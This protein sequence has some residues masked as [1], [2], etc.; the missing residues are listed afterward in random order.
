MTYGQAVLWLAVRLADGLAHAH[1]RGILHR[2][3]KPAN[4]L[5]TDEGQ[6]M[7]LDFNLSQDTKPQARAS[8]AC[9]GGTLPYMAPEH[10]EALQGGTRPVDARSD[11]YSLGVVLYELLTG[12]HPFPVR[13]GPLPGLLAAMHADRQGPPPDVRRWHKA[14]SPAVESIVRH[15]L[16]PVPDRRYQSAGQLREDLQCQLENRPLRHA[17][18]P[19]WA[20]RTRKWARRHPRLTS[21]TSVGALA[22]LVV[23]VL[24]ALL[25]L[26]GH[27]LAQQE[28]LGSRRQLAEDLK[29]AHFLLN[30]PD[31][32]RRQHEEGLALC[33][34]AA[35]RY[36][37]LDKPAWQETPLVRALPSEDRRRLRED[38]GELLFL[39][40]RALAWEAA[41]SPDPA[42]RQ[43]QAQF[44][45]QLNARAG[46]CYAPTEAP[47]AVGLQ[48]AHLT[49]LT[50]DEAE[51]RRRREQAEQVPLRT[52]R[53]RYLLVLHQ[54]D[55]G[56]MH[57][58]LAFLREASREGPPDASVWLVLGN[59]YAALGQRDQAT[60]HYE[61][62]IA[63][64]PKSHWAYF[65]RGLLH[66]ENGRPQRAAADFDRVLELRPGMT[67]AYFN[68]ALA[69]LRAGR[70]A[71]ALADFSHILETEE[72]PPTRVFLARARVRAQL[73]DRE[74]QRQ[75]LEEGLRREPTDDNDCLAR[76]VA[77]YA[78]DPKG[79]LA[80]FEKALAFNPLSRMALQNQAN[81]LAEKLGRPAEA[82]GVLDRLLTLYPDSVLALAGRG[83][84]H[85]RLGAREAALRDAQ[86]ALAR[87]G[88]PATLYRVAGIYAQTSRQQPGDRQEAL[89]HLSAALQKGYGRELLSTDSDLG[90]LRGQV[91]FRRLLEAPP[92]AAGQPAPSRRP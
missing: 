44:A 29:T 76:G 81:V 88:S 8:R 9:V 18:E 31:A 77:K 51:A 48:R 46:D 1:E 21:W 52:F 4:I 83:V 43:E 72:R 19:S 6:P 11:L 39:W 5:L 25:V 27:R 38:L 42:R 24:M 62:G 12:R 59:C 87:D 13:H 73:G 47:R 75:D 65:N 14:V 49:L 90:P 7:L 22:G 35:E 92:P 82:I 78:R 57:Q 37:V 84:L 23:L 53:E 32:G 33:R 68:R 70:P 61:A 74:G 28:A 86:A 20:E 55:R 2:D 41:A 79:A 80:D 34:R 60:A 40:A 30:R 10:L 64:A 15:C 3:L 45:L 67:E 71:D 91:E 17:P 54:M 56:G 66:L 63:L 36:G 16:E 69:R 26:R 58:A 50:G 85:A 89:H